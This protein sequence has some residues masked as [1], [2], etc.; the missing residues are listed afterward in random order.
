M[1]IYLTVKTG[2]WF[3]SLD[4]RRRTVGPLLCGMLLV[5]FLRLSSIDLAN[6]LILAL[7]L[8]V[9]IGVGA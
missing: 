8:L 2:N 5:F 7:G 4:R 9:D 6:I 1:V 3:K